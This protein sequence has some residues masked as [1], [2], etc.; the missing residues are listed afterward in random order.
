MAAAPAADNC[1]WGEIRREGL[2]GSAEASEFLF[3]FEEREHHRT[4]GD[5]GGGVGGGAAADGVSKRRGQ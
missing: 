4:G 5:C 1:I 2:T 3:F